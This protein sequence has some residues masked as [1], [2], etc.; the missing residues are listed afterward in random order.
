MWSS[1]TDRTKQP[2]NRGHREGPID[3]ISAARGE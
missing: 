3:M 2:L 1:V